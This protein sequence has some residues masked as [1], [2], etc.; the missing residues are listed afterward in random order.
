MVPYEYFQSTVASFS[1]QLTAAESDQPEDHTP[2]KSQYVL[3][4]DLRDQ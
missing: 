3:K 1:M 2:Q 4:R